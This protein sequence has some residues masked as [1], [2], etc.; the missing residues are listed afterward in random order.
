MI[1]TF[2]S[3]QTFMTGISVLRQS[4]FKSWAFVGAAALA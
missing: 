2:A 4:G 1:Q 3:L